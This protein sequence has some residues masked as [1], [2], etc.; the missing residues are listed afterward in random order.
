MRGEESEIEGSWASRKASG[1]L[2]AGLK[3]P[4]EPSARAC[5]TSRSNSCFKEEGERCH[6][7]L[8]SGY[9]AQYCAIA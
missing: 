9:M 3:P 6:K 1:Q 8:D 7:V 2:R 4:M 5:L